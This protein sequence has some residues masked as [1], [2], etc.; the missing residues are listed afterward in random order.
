MRTVKLAN[1]MIRQNHIGVIGIGAVGS[2]CVSSLIHKD[3]VHKISVFD[4]D[5]KRCLGEVLDLQDEA[6]I[7][8][9]HVQQST[10]I[11]R[12]GKFSFLGNVY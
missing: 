1:T 3:S 12:Y 7:K 4:I 10:V 5:E 2:S 11:Y 6:F 8:G 9:T